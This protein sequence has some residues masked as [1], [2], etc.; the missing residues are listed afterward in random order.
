MAEHLDLQPRA[1]E[2]A[3]FFQDGGSVVGHD[4]NLMFAFASSVSSGG[5]ARGYDA[6][7]RMA[8][9]YPEGFAS[10]N[11]VAGGMRMPGAAERATMQQI[12]REFG[13]LY[14]AQAMVFVGNGVWLSSM[15]LV[16]ATMMLAIPKAFPQRVFAEFQAALTWV[17]EQADSAASFDER[18]LL[19]TYR[20]HSEA[21]PFSG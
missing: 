11:V 1:E 7:R 17:R 21:P 4:G 5:V 2:Q 10:V 9:L 12:A 14:L 19:Q 15:R 16:A 20:E 3:I 6:H 8:T 18:R 13:G